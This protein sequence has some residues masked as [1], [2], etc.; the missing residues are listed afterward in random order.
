MRLLR[1]SRRPGPGASG[2][3][4]TF[5][6]G[7]IE[8]A[9]TRCEEP[10]TVARIRPKDPYAEWLASHEQEPPE[11]RWVYRPRGGERERPAQR[12]ARLRAGVA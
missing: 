5:V 8:G 4:L 10:I 6:P 1:A 11:I 3:I 2:P 9:E 12:A 7:E